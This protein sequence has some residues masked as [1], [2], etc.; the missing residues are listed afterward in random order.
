LPND[1]RPRPGRPDFNF[2]GPIASGIF[3]P[4]SGACLDRRRRFELRSMQR[5][6][7]WL[8]LDVPAVLLW[9]DLDLDDDSDPQNQ[10]MY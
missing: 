8:V 2:N 5:G 10:D 4:Y 1:H 6:S 3:N 7:D 9:T